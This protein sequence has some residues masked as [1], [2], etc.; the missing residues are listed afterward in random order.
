MEGLKLYGEFQRFFPILVMR[1][2][3]RIEEIDVRHNERV[4]GASKYGISRIPKAFLDLFAVILLASYGN[5][6]LHLFG[7]VGI[8]TGLFGFGINAYLTVFK[9]ATGTIGGHNTL[10]LVGVMLMVLGLQWF[11][12]GIL[13]ELINNYFKDASD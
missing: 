11:S 13:G 10:L 12:T 3:F 4:H 7:L 5:R 8:L 9:L 1:K 6:P 2:G